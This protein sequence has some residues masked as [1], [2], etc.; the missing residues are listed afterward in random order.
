MA[1]IDTMIPALDEFRKFLG[2]YKCFIDD[3]F[4]IWTGSEEEFLAF[5]K[6]INTLHAKINFTCSSNNRESDTKY[7]SLQIRKRRILDEKVFHQITI[8]T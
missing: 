3:I 8:W 2:F 6:K 4:I 1:M 7:R 5:M